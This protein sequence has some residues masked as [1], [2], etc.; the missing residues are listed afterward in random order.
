MLR[1][2]KRSSWW[3]PASTMRTSSF[4][5]R[6]ASG[7]GDHS[8]FINASPFP[9]QKI[10]A[11]QSKLSTIV[12]AIPPIVD[13]IPGQDP[14][15]VASMALDSGPCQGGDFTPTQKARIDGF[16]ISGANEGGAILVNAFAHYLEIS[17]NRLINNL[18]IWEVASVSGRRLW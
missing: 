7:L 1:L 16:T 15:F 9:S 14:Q 8:T 6:P 13:L 17:N 10:A 2:R 3:N 12:N 18:G 5:K 4:I 11:W